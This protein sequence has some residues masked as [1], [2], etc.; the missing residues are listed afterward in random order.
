MKNFNWKLFIILVILGSI[1]VFALIP[2]EMAMFNATEL[3]PEAAELD[4]VVVTVI[5]SFSKVFMVVVAVFFGMLVMR[6]TG[7]GAP[8]IESYVAKEKLPK[9]SWRWFNL[10][11]VISLIGSLI[12]L[13]LDRFI[14]MPQI[15]VQLMNKPSPTWWHGLLAMFYGGI[16]E[17]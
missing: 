6:R 16:T 2:Y 11:I 4:P 14:F 9:F 17:E 8:F 15:D 5:N 1:G 12:V 3:P 13:V 10:A 7:L